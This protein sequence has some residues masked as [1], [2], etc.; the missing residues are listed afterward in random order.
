VIDSELRD[1]QRAAARRRQGLMARAWVAV[2]RALARRMSAEIGPAGW[3]IDDTG[4]LAIGRR[5]QASLANILA[6]VL[7]QRLT[8]GAS[9]RLSSD[10]PRDSPQPAII[11]FFAFHLDEGGCWH[12]FHF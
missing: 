2:R 9:H 3:V 5:R 6:H 11:L 8:Q 12:A 4:F 10:V 7:L 1:S